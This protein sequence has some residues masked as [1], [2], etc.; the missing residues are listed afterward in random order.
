MHRLR[1]IARLSEY[2]SIDNNRRVCCEHG[3]LL[4]TP[5]DRKRLL[6]REPGDVVAW[7]LPRQKCFV[8]VRAHNQVWHANL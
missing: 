7:S 6:P 2:L 1:R 5:P 4:T 3:Q 8:D